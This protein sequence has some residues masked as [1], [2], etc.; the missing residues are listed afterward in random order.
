MDNRTNEELHR[1]LWRWLAETG[2]GNK[3]DWPEWKHN[4]GMYVACASCFACQEAN[5]ICGGCCLPKDNHCPIKWG[6]AGRGCH[7]NGSPLVSWFLS[8]KDTRKKYAA[9]I[10]EL[11]WREG[12]WS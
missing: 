6:K 2:S 9:I 3:E 12:G 7:A 11:P 5:H 10:A 1:A 8:N 4:G